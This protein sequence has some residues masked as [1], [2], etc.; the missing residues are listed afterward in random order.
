[1]PRLRVLTLTDQLIA[2][3][4]AER[5][6]LEI[7]KRLDRERFES[8]F[9][10][11]RF[12]G[13]AQSGSVEVAERELQAAGIRYLGLGRRSTLDVHRWLPLYRLLRRER[14]D[15]IHAHMFGSNAWG[16]LLG[17]LARVP[18]VVAHEHTWS[19]EGQPVR[20]IVDREL[21]GRGSDVFVA[22]SGEDRRK[23]IELERIRPEKVL[24]MPNGIPAPAPPSGRDIR[25]ELGIPA[26]APVIGTVSVLRPQKALNL[27]VEASAALRCDLAALWTVI[28]GEGPERS[29]LEAL[30]SRLG[31][32]DRIVLTGYRADVSDVL[33]ALDV[34]VSS[35]AFEGSP[36]A[37]MEFMEAGRPIVATRVGG[38]PDLIEDGVHGLLVEPGDAEALTNAIRRQL[39]DTAAAGAMG[40]AAR[41]RRRD[42][43]D[44]ALTVR[45]FEALYERLRAGHP[46]PAS[47]EELDPRPET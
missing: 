45:R 12:S 4:G 3:G 47:A 15:V 18:V 22:V 34:A 14:F 42:R 7:A 26:D 31:V 32:D 8:V 24:V 5:I 44:I 29:A 28:V 25:A 10:A 39:T 16:T 27:L 20:R 46:P 17:R 9:C 11:S 19:F 40:Q 13:I 30:A 36:L 1:M 37:M 23:M 41:E 43:F 35:S 33:A 6:A 21:I 38:V 2:L